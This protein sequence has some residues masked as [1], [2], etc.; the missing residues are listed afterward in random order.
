MGSAI[1]ENIV[2]CIGVVINLIAKKPEGEWYNAFP[3]KGAVYDQSS[4]ALSCGDKTVRI[5]A[6]GALGKSG[7]PRAVGPLMDLLDDR[8]PEIRMAAVTGLGA[9]KSG[10]SVEALLKCLL[11]RDEHSVMREEAAASLASIRSSGA[12]RG[13]RE[14]IADESEDPQI[15]SCAEKILEKAGSR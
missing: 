6:V 10:R 15:R 9:L 8:D 2:S 14:F 5:H 3:R 11:D 12:I 1:S 13:L 4:A 7:D